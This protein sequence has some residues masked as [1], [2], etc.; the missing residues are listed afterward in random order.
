M[1]ANRLERY[2]VLCGHS[3]GRAHSRAGDPIAA[4]AYL[5]KSDNFDRAVATYA[6]AYAGQVQSDYAAF[7]EA[8]QDGRVPVTR[9][10]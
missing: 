7:M 9:L 2:A 8:I 3:L 1:G 4:S 10:A 5:G 6:Q